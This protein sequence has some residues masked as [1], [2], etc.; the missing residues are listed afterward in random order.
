[1]AENVLEITDGNFETEVINSPIPVLVDLWAEW[2]GPCRMMAPT[3]E[4][5]AEEYEGKAKI[6]KLN[7][8]ENRDTSVKLN[9]TAIPTLLIYN[10]GEIVKTLV[11]VTSKK[12]LKAAL[13]ELV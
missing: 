1:M 4:E 5:L 7:T 3:I 8:D 9:I 10:K 6:G 2:C 11:G 12:D 13:D